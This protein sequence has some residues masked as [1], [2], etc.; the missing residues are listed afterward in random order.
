V[1]VTGQLEEVTSFHGNDLERLQQL[2][3]QPWAAG[4][5][6]L[7]LR[8]RPRFITGRNVRHEQTGS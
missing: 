7:W 6:K 3:V 8:L 5:R 4:E 1:L 2:P